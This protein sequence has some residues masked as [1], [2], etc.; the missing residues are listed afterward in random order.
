MV[1][2]RPP[3]GWRVEIDWLI[4]G[5]RLPVRQIV[6]RNENLDMGA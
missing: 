6:A 3:S 2:E 4:T 1:H 5:A